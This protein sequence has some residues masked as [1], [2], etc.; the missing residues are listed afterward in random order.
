MIIWQPGQQINNGR[1]IIQG[2]AL[3]SGGFGITYKALEPST[4]KLYAIKTL[5]ST[6]QIREDFAEQQVKFIN[7]ALTIKGFD[8]PH[9]LKV[10]EVIQEG[11]LFGVVMEYIDGETLFQYAQNKGQLSESEALL[12]IDQIGRALEYIHDKAQLHR[13]I[14]PQ[15]ILLRQNKQEAV[16]ID[17]GLTRSI[18]T[19]SMTN[20]FTEG[21]APIEQYRR[22]G[23]FGSYT[24]VYALAATLYYLLTAD[25]LKKEGEVTPVPAQNRKYD[26][27]PLPEPKHYNSRISQRVNDAILQGME[28]EPEKRTPT[29]LK[30]RENLGLVV[31]PR[32][33]PPPNPLPAS[34]E[35]GLKSSVGMD[36]RKLR[37]LLAQGK[38]K[39]VDEETKQVMLAVAKREKEGWLYEEHID[40]FPCEDLR[41][42]DQ[43]W[44]KYSDGKFGFSVQKRIYQ[45]LGGTRE[46]DL[47]IWDKFGDKVGWRKGGSWLYY[48]D[49]TFDKKAPEGHLPCGWYGEDFWGG[50]LI[51]VVGFFSRVETCR[52]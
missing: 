30:F 41:T 24:D 42:I 44:V 28:I 13:D 3:G 25:G 45:G 29:V 40:N 4:G 20:S 6:M 26:D 27:E 16:L 17:F 7:E 21:Y 5:N 18:A 52:L 12:Y 8:Y 14:K 49:I 46:Y 2:K 11:Q 1:F 43:L 48:K 22:K 33:T 34:E 19:K 32:R 50:M 39:E 23:S 47:D 15:N 35:G 10:Y 31:Q 51:R 37:D 9:I 38:W 36:Y